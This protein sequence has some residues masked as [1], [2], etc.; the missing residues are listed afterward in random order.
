MEV[1]LEFSS[2]A[3]KG[4]EITPQKKIL[5]GSWEPIEATLNT[6]SLWS[7]TFDI[8]ARLLMTLRK[9]QKVTFLKLLMFG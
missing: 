4:Y 3:Q 9:P 7:P 1:V 2:L 6:A 8:F 5:F